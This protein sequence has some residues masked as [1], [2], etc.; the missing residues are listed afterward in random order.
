MWFWHH[1]GA[2]RDPPGHGEAGMAP[3]LNGGRLFSGTFSQCNTS[4]GGVHPRDHPE[5][6]FQTLPEDN[7]PPSH[8]DRSRE[9]FCEVLG[10]SGSSLREFQQRSRCHHLP[11]HCSSIHTPHMG[12]KKK[13][14]AAEALAS[15]NTSKISSKS[16]RCRKMPRGA[17]AQHGGHQV[18]ASAAAGRR[19]EE[20][21][22]QKDEV[23]HH[24]HRA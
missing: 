20:V 24:Q 5:M 10:P 14:T 12:G 21:H 8:V 13:G 23:N 6:S 4:R 2:L 16:L 7:S 1:Q 15:N 9:C 22:G 11:H 3:A 17:L 18:Q 19:G